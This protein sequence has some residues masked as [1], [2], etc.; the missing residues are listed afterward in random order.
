[1][2]VCVCVFE[3]RKCKLA[4]ALSEKA[5]EKQPQ[6]KRN[7]H[8]V[9]EAKKKTPTAAVGVHSLL[10]NSVPFHPNSRRPVRGGGGS[11]C[12]A[13]HVPNSRAKL[14]KRKPEKER[15]GDGLVF[16]DRIRD[17][18]GPRVTNLTGAGRMKSKHNKVA[19]KREALHSTQGN[20]ATEKESFEN[21][22]LY[23]GVVKQTN[24]KNNRPQKAQ[25]SKYPCFE[26]KRPL[27]WR[28]R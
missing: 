28:T 2:C 21:G 8:E 7:S 24:N 20:R 10:V 12:L 5:A 25:R 13:S 6:N 11:F 3:S 14:N 23:V 19:A 17:E 15:A 27:L 4:R 1:M 16:T 18:Q 22:C 9:R 26:S